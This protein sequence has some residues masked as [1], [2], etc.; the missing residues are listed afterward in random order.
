MNSNIKHRTL[1]A[2]IAEQLRQEILSGAYPAGAQLRQDALAAHYD[3]S[4]IP[5]R[6]ALFQLEAEGL[7]RM[8]PHKGAVVTS[9]SELE[10]N[11]IFDLRALLEPRLFSHSIPN[12]TAEDFLQID[13]I[14]SQFEEA[15]RDQNLVQWGTLN[16]QLHTALYARANLPQTA[17]TVAGLL[18]KSDRDTRV[19][20]SST[21][22]QRKA[23]REHSTLI[24]LAKTREIA[25]ACA[26]LVEH[27]ESVRHD[28]LGLI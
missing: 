14:Q 6:E 23:E 21:L 7:V 20:L 18:Q 27:I 24:Q 3:V 5:V 26:F 8:L 25:A 1:S 2:R 17:A 11:D 15:I 16:S 13:T 9:L 10:V 28:L 22:A 4:R 19:Q 12:L